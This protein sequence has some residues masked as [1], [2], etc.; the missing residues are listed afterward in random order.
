MK[1]YPWK[2]RTC[3]EA[4]ARPVT[5]DY[6]TVIEHDGRSYPVEV[7]GLDVVACAKCGAVVLDDAANQRISDALRAAV[8]LLR[9]E[10]IREARKSLG[11]TQKQ[12]AAF[13][14][15]SEFTVSRWENGEQ[16][17]QKAMNR[18]MTTF[19]NCPEARTYTAR[20][21]GV[22]L[23]CPAKGGHPFP[24][25]LI[26]H[27]AE[28]MAGGVSPFDASIM[29][30]VDAQEVHLACPYLGLPYLQ[31]VIRRSK[32]WRLL[33]DVQAWLASEAQ[34]SRALAVNF[35]LAHRDH[36]H[37]CKD[38]HAKVLI[39][40]RQALIGSANFTEKGITGRV[41]MGALF[42][43][44]A[45]IEELQTW[46]DGLWNLTGPIDP[47]EL[48]ACEATLPSPIPPSAASVLG[49]SFPGIQSRLS[50]NDTTTS[51]AKAVTE[52]PPHAKA[53]NDAAV[54]LVQ[55]YGK[56]GIPTKKLKDEI[57]R[58][59]GGD[60]S[61]YRPSDYCYNRI[62]Q[63][64]SS[65]RYPLLL[66]LPGDRYQYLGPDFAYDGEVWWKPKDK[67]ERQVIGRWRHGMLTLDYDPRPETGS[68]KRH[69]RAKGPKA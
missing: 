10:E 57:A 50:L 15:V 49:C 34:E 4:A 54:L 21:A 46:F 24:A 39:A 40:G 65:G 28:T 1:P 60:A 55:T 31:R 63:A 41:E 53:V 11:L 69:G 36:V 43:G 59:R 58:I 19:F 33:T 7:P 42:E 64:P 26:Y 32:A 62:N 47:I 5:M 30:M 44:G 56:N 14:D 25:R 23:P 48:R 61:G 16:I 8:G 13:L 6:R 52:L 9:P 17:Q 12:L 67:S 66:W 45:H 35:I 3:R 2:C 29:N 27:T 20:E 51:E 68:S 18:L 22:Q 37:H 38:L